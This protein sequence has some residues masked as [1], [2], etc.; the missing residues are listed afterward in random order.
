MSCQT[1]LFC[2]ENGELSSDRRNVLNCSADMESGVAVGAIP[3]GASK[4]LEGTIRV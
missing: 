2:S 1:P 3:S 4:D